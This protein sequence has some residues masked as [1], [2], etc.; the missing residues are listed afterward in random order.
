M[1]KR[2]RRVFTVEEKLRLLEE[3]REPNTSVA[4]VLRHNGLDAATFDRGS[5]P[6][7]GLLERGAEAGHPLQQCGSLP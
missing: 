1:A 6:D 2:R 5:D 3:A 7:S 4:E